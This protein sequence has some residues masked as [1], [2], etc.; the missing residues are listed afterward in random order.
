VHK[1]SIEIMFYVDKV[2]NND[3]SF[4]PNGTVQ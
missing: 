4:A 2:S 3:R 1:I